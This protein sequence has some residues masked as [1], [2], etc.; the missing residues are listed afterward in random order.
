M[1]H[2]GNF[3]LVDIVEQYICPM[4]ADT[5]LMK[6][7]FYKLSVYKKAALQYTCIYI[8]VH[9]CTVGGL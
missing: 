7:D 1:F 9:A 6:H 4:C 3:L 8:Y 5:S 2:A